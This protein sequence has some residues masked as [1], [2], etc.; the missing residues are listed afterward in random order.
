M[1]YEH[2]ASHAPAAGG[3]GSIL[4]TLRARFHNWQIRKNVTQMQNLDDRILS[5]IGVNHDDVVWATKLPLSVNA[6]HE[7]NKVSQMRRRARK[8]L[9]GGA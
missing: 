9:R 6:A 1:T 2:T 3:N 4:E 7:L 8:H 5:D